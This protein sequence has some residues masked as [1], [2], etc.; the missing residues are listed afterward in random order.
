M[1]TNNKYTYKILKLI[2]IIMV[3]VVVIQTYSPFTWPLPHR[4]QTLLR[5]YP[6]S[7][8]RHWNE[9]R[10]LPDCL[11]LSLST[12]HEVHKITPVAKWS[13][14][15]Q[16]PHFV[17]SSAFSPFSRCEQVHYN[18][19]GPNLPIWMIWMLVSVCRVAFNPSLM[20]WTSCFDDTVWI[21][22]TW[23]SSQTRQCIVVSGRVLTLTELLPTAPVHCFRWPLHRLRN[24][25]TAPLHVE[26]GMS[27]NR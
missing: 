25:Y 10:Y 4:L 19:T 9:S 17:T 8:T 22:I 21:T 24:F 27:C 18:F 11:S 1:W 5:C 14:Q 15:V 13:L 2:T 7:L 12:L 6:M 16:P 26:L 3:I 23:A 20:N